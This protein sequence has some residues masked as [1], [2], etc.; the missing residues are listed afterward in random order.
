[1]RQVKLERVENFIRSFIFNTIKQFMYDGKR[2]YASSEYAIRFIDMYSIS[3]L[4]NVLL[5]KLML[6]VVFRV[7]ES[8]F[9]PFSPK[10][11]RLGSILR[12]R[13]F[14]SKAEVRAWYEKR[15]GMESIS[16]LIG[17]MA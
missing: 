10:G 3:F 1:M 2:G 4:C 8:V 11:K 17:D 14:I 7:Y 5:N 9:I 16:F 13:S 15:F 6:K 12:G